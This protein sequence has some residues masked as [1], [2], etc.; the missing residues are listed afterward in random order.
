MESEKAESQS[1]DLEKNDG[2]IEG[3]GPEEAWKKLAASQERAEKLLQAMQSQNNFLLDRVMGLNSMFLDQVS[4][5]EQHEKAI[6][7][8][9]KKFQTG[10]AQ[11]AMT[12]VYIKLFR[13]LIG[14]LNN[15]DDLVGLYEDET[16][17]EGDEQW[18][19]AILVLR[20]GFVDLLLNWGV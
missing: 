17:A 2:M 9:L 7:T 16:P 8:E 5:M 20:D 13:D 1:K 4:R 15:M 19:R 18:V 11:R 6:E 10:G 14:Q 3:A 12:S